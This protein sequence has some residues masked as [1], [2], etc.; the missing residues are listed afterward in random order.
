MFEKFSLNKPELEQL[1]GNSIIEARNDIVEKV[2]G[3][4]IKNGKPNGR[5]T[6]TG[7]K[8]L[9]FER[10]VYNQQLSPDG[11]LREPY[12]PYDIINWKPGQPRKGI[13]DF[14]HTKGNSYSQ[15]FEKYKNNLITLD[16]LKEFQYNPKNFRIEKPSSNRNHFYE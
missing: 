2:N 15:M 5:P 16:E 12:P 7:K 10:E 3:P 1:A 14:G 6:L 13:V 4:Y 8:K 11:I 9:E